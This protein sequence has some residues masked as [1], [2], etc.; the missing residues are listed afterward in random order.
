MEEVREM[1]WEKSGGGT[2]MSVFMAIFADGK[3]TTR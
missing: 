2:G 1:M 3:T